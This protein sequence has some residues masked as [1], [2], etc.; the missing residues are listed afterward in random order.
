VREG[1]AALLRPPRFEDEDRD[2]QAALLHIALLVLMASTVLWLTVTFH[3]E[4]DPTTRLAFAA[5]ALAVP[6]VAFAA[7]RLRRTM[8]A[9]LFL[10][11][12]FWLLF[13]AAGWYAGGLGRSLGAAYL[14]LVVLSGL[15]LGGWAGVGAAIL[16]Y[17][18][19][20]LLSYAKTH[21]WLP[22]AR[23]T[24]TGTIPALLF[25]AFVFVALFLYLADRNLARALR[26]RREHQRE[27]EVGRER[28][29]TLTENAV[30]LISEMDAEGR[31]VYVSPQHREL[32]G[33]DP[34]EL[35]GTAAIDLV[36]PDDRER[37]ARPLGAAITAGD[38]ETLQYRCRTKS[39]G[40]RHI[41]SSGRAYTSA[42]GEIRVVVVSMDVDERVR[43]ETAL[44]DAEAQLRISQRMES[45]G[46]LAGGVAHDFNNLLTVILGSAR[47]LE[48]HSDD[49]PESVRDLASEIVQSA[50]KSA[51]LT[52]QLLAFSRMQIVET[53]VLDLDERIEQLSR[54]LK[55]LVGDEVTIVIAS[56]RGE[57]L[58]KADPSQIEQ[59]IVNL[60]ANAR[61]AMPTG[62]TLSIRTGQARLEEGGENGA[63]GL[64]A[65]DY[66][67]LEVADTGLGMTPDTLSHIFEPFFTTKELG[68]GTGLGLSTVYGIVKQCGGEIEVESAPGGGSRFRVLL[69]RLD[70]ASVESKAAARES[71]APTGQGE[72]VLLAEDSPRVRQFTSRVLEEGGYRV[73][74]ASDGVEAL[75]R[76]RESPGDFDAL[77]TD[78]AMP[79]MGGS[80]LARRCVELNP[81]IPVIFVSAY[82]EPE[83]DDEALHVTRS[84]WLKKPFSSNDLL[85]SIRRLLDED[86]GGGE[87]A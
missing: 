18:S 43:A 69:P 79:G 68:S 44:R 57:N 74:Q 76:L 49:R 80:E 42:D 37:I 35:L 9:V 19:A 70:H 39:G 72:H 15:L 86:G 21:A 26:E 32:L 63:T 2:R 56:G 14:M 84:R 28:Y 53:Q 67:S 58:V 54:I 73:T 36:H 82:A 48:Q 25:V 3:R 85:F 87:G 64:A 71:T 52:R 61:D 13:T 51:D 34:E 29:R 22:E 5:A 20:F 17:F 16:C 33:W 78:V 66:V 59:L 11:T 60:V 24:E 50:E 7:L 47:W 40:F 55:S 6:A 75:E 8:F 12:A 30:T 10:L 4:A 62:G 1:L 27:T 46:R 41:E 45:L 38:H 23:I 31:L 83:L 81:R 65:G 77:L